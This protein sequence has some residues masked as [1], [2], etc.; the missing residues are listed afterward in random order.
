[1]AYFGYFAALRLRDDRRIEL[2]P[3]LLP[4]NLGEI[5]VQCMQRLALESL[6]TVVELRFCFSL[7]DL[8]AGK[9]CGNVRLIDRY[10]AST[11]VEIQ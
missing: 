1:M 8:H 3:A 5:R 9:R 10:G 7:K 11:R 4:L 2:A 6:L